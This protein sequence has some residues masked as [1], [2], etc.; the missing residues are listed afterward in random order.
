MNATWYTLELS[1]AEPPR[2]RFVVALAATI[3]VFIFW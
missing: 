2:A 3:L 1:S